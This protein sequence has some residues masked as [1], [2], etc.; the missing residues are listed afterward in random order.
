MP[1]PQLAAF[2]WLTAPS[3]NNRALTQARF[4]S[5]FPARLLNPPIPAPSAD[6]PGSR[7][8][9]GPSAPASAPRLLPL[10][11]TFFLSSPIHPFIHATLIHAA[12]P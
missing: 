5:L 11:W 10:Y 8:Q 2:L 9:R 3:S 12:P 4:L 6:H 7:P 1:A